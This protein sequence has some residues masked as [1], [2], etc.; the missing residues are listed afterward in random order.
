MIYSKFKE[1]NFMQI[2]KIKKLLDNSIKNTKKC[3][4]QKTK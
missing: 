4:T 2:K 1:R 3:I